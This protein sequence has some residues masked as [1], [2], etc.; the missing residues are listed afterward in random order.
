MSQPL[1]A[2]QGAG[3]PQPLVGLSALYQ[4]LHHLL[5]PGLGHS[6]PGPNWNRHSAGSD[7]DLI[8]PDPVPITADAAA[9]ATAP[10]TALEAANKDDVDGTAN[11]PGC[12]FNFVALGITESHRYAAYGCMWL[13]PPPLGPRKHTRH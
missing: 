5:L 12:I 10:N 9:V 6:S 1:L 3:M 4:Q 7:S 11:A 8:S 2:A 13:P